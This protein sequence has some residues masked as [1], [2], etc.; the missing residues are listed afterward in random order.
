MILTMKS[1]SIYPM[2]LNKFLAHAAVSSRRAAEALI[3]D[4]VVTVNQAPVR[5]PGHRVLEC[6]VVVVAGKRVSLRKNHVYILLNKPKNYLSTCSDEQGRRTVLHALKGLPQELD[7]ERIYPVGRLDRNST[8]LLLLTNDGELAHKLAHPSSQ[9]AKVYY[10]LLDKPL[11]ERDE[12]ALS[13]GVLLSDGI[14][15]VDALRFAH[16]IKR[17]AIRITLHSGK[18]RIIRRLFEALGYS[19]R[20]LDRIS[21]AGLT[22]QNLSC[23]SWRFLTSAEINVLKNMV[24]V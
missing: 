20:E 13:R 14:V 18:N 12:H 11:L 2:Q 6:D 15:Q 8:G 7:S 17:D 24:H 19:V 22:T 16:A 1:T 3:R 9:I 4:G 21:Y 5:D 23:G 10:V